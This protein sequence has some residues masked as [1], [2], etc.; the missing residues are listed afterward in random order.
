MTVGPFIDG[1]D[2]WVPAEQFKDREDSLLLGTVGL[3]LASV[4]TADGAL[5]VAQ[6]ADRL[7]A[8]ATAMKLRALARVEGHRRRTEHRR[9]PAAP[10]KPAETVRRE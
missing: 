10:R 5:Q 1:E 3:P 8:W 6:T 9:D 7:I 4:L 2:A